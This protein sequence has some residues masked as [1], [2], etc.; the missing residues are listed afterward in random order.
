MKTRKYTYWKDGEYYLGYWNE[1]PEYQTQALSKDELIENLKS[2]LF[3]L[4]S[5]EV[6]YIRKEEEIV[7]A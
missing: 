1:Y 5:G 6:P 2:L 7:L 3:D 4:E